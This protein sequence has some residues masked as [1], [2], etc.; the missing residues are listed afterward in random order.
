MQAPVHRLGT[1]TCLAISVA[2]VGWGLGASPALA[3]TL[4]V[5]TRVDA[6]PSAGECASPPVAGDCSLRQAV[7]MANTNPGSMI[8]L[9][10][11][12]YQLTIP[13]GGADDNSTGDLNLTASTT[14]AGAGSLKTV[15][16]A[17]TTASDGLDRVLTMSGS[18]VVHIQGVTVR[19]GNATM[20]GGGILDNSTGLLSISGSA[21]TANHASYGGGIDEEAGG[22]V[23]IT[24]S[25][26]SDNTASHFGAGIAQDGPGPIGISRSTIEDNTAIWD[27]GGIA[28]EFAAPVTITQSTINGNTASYGG[29]IVEEGGDPPSAPADT[30]INDTITD[31]HAV[32]GGRVVADTGGGGLDASGGGGTFVVRNSTISGNTST[33]TTGGNI[34]D[35][36]DPIDLTNTIVA[37]GSPANCAGGSIFFVGGHGHGSAA[38]HNLISDATCGASAGGTLVSVNPRLAPLVDAGGSTYTQP[39][40]AGSPAL[41]AAKDAFCPATDQRGIHRPQGPHCDIGA[42]EAPAGLLPTITSLI[43]N[44]GSPGQTETVDI[45]GAH[46]ASGAKAHFGPAISVSAMSFISATHLRAHIS[47][48]LAA[49]SGTR[50]VSVVNPNGG[51][52]VCTLCFVVSDPSLP[53]RIVFQSNRTGK[54]Q[55]YVMRADGTHVARLTH[56][57]A[58]DVGAAWSPSGLKIAF[59]SD[60][61]GGQ[62]LYVM[63]AN[64]T[65]VTQLTHQ[66][67]VWGQPTWSPNG[68]MLADENN[69]SGHFQIYTLHSTGTGLT[70]ITHDTHD[71][72]AVSWSSDGTELVF[73]SNLSGHFEIYKMQPNGAGLIQLTNNPGRDGDPEWSPDGKHIV[74]DSTRDGNPEIYVMNT[75]GSAQTRLTNNPAADINPTW[76]HDSKWIAFQSNRSGNPEIFTMKADGSSQ[77]ERTYTAPAVNDGATWTG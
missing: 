24:G 4:T 18:A 35:D 69:H 47:L 32:G 5:N 20:G 65:G 67:G 25:S 27:G 8:A 60:R 72:G 45:F 57:S 42:Y 1:R 73:D 55:L 30:L 52:G 13:P 66:S 28:E 61:S 7:D 3:V 23:S 11:G 26:I 10:A 39:L 15:V 75:D 9:P 12:T 74:F 21:L 64:G 68:S 16:E 41:N 63:N 31:N 49:T 53:G 51:A 43:P 22:S 70:R 48:A 34:H 59:V 62:Q 38:G 36:I 76:S 46:F 14:I 6:A 17:G 19:F 71:Y 2:A 29:G 33:V 40:L 44:S 77:I 58:N 50:S 37:G 56:D 54:Y